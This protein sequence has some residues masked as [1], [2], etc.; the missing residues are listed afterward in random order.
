ME[1]VL[2]NVKKKDLAVFKS[3]A[4]SLGFEIEKKEKPYNPEFVK[5]ILE[6]EKSIKEG[7]GVRMTMEELKELCK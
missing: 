4:K 5:E 6:A 2:K 3:L 7:R 1:L